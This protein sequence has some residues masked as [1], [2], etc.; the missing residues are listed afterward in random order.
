M[1]GTSKTEADGFHD[2]L[3]TLFDAPVPSLDSPELE[4]RVLVRIAQRRWMRAGVVGFS[5]LVGLSISF[6]S[7]AEARLPVF[8]A[9]SLLEAA[10]NSL[11]QFL[12]LSLGS[13]LPGVAATCGVLTVLG[14][15]FARYLE[16]V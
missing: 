7:L 8:R 3:E 11:S 4:A 9:D 13:G 14:L 2:R 5:A 12:S 1:N 6:R 10:G 15:A 16:E